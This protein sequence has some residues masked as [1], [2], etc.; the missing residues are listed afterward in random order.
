MPHRLTSDHAR[1]SPVSSFRASYD[2]MKKL[3]GN[4][5]TRSNWKRMRSELGRCR[6]VGHYPRGY[7]TSVV[8]VGELKLR[9]IWKSPCRVRSEGS[10]TLSRTGSFSC[11]AN[12]ARAK[13]SAFDG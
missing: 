10:H 5:S 7:H 3:A 6:R 13:A 8:G 12:L 1:T 2:S 9:V 4:P 11:K